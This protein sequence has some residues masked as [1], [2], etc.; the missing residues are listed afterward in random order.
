MKALILGATG[1]LGYELAR[2][3]PDGVDIFPY[4]RDVVDLA[5]PESIESAVE[6]VQPNIIINAAAYTAVDKAESDADQAY[7]ANV[8]G[9]ECLAQQAARIGARLVHVSTDF[10]FSGKSDSP[11]KTT[12]KTEPLGVYGATKRDG[13]VALLKALPSGVIVR[14]AWVYSA[15]GNNFVKTMLRLMRDKDQL[16][17]VAD[18]RGTP[19]W[20]SGLAQACWQLGLNEAAQ[21]IYH[22]TDAGECSW[23]DFACEIQR[24]ALV[25]GLLG[26]AIPVSPI[27]ASEY[28]TPAA[29]P[30]YSVLDKSRIETDLGLQLH[31]WQ[32]QLRQMLEELV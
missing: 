20:A 3:A 5:K 25:L 9:V 12:D 26:K 24:Q 4:A 6:R 16:S 31:P 17:V 29:R 8:A 1:Q 21:G 18:Q 22:Y 11:Y 14:T 32:Q 19:T 27:A 7:L 2:T 13:E 10:V 30:Y 15:H 28:P 23:Y